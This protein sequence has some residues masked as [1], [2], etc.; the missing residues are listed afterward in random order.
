MKESIE[1]GGKR[2]VDYTESD[3]RF[4]GWEHECIIIDRSEN[5]YLIPVERYEELNQPR[6][7]T[8]KII[9][10]KDGATGCAG[11]TGVVGSIGYDWKQ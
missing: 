4:T 3:L 2:F 1:I 10:E 9:N 5:H 8:Q 6:Q 11:D 7:T